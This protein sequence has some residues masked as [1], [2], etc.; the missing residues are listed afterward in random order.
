MAFNGIIN[1]IKSE[2]DSEWYFIF[3]T[4]CIRL[5]FVFRL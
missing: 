1:T 5:I 3:Q 2:V 4:D